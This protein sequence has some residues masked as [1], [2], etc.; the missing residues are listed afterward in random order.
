M[1]ST[2]SPPSIA[3][4]LTNLKSIVELSIQFRGDSLTSTYGAIERL[5][6]TILAIL[7]H[8]IKQNGAD[9][10]EQL[11]QIIVRLNGKSQRYINLLQ[12]IYYRENIRLSVEQWI[13][14]SL[15]K[16]CLSNQL[17]EIE[18][19]HDLLENYYHQSAFLRLTAYY[20]AF[21]L[22]LRTIEFNDP[23]LL[24]QIDPKLSIVTLHDPSSILVNANNLQDDQQEKF[25]FSA[26]QRIVHRRNQSDPIFRLQK[27]SPSPS[28]IVVSDALPT[29]SY[30]QPDTYGSYGSSYDSRADLTETNGLICRNKSST[31]TTVNDQ[32]SNENQRQS[33]SSQMTLTNPDENSLDQTQHRLSPLLMQDDTMFSTNSNS[34][35]EQ[36]VIDTS[37][38][39]PLMRTPRLP[40]S[41]LFW[42]RKGQ[43]LD[44]Y[45]RESDSKTRTDVEKE[46]AHFYLSE[47]ILSAVEQIKFTQQCQRYLG[48][49]CSSSITSLISPCETIHTSSS[50]GSASPLPSSVS[51]QFYTPCN[52]TLS[53]NHRNQSFIG[54]LTTE[55]SI[56]DS[57]PPST[58]DLS[59]R[60][61][62]FSTSQG[63]SSAETIAL[64]LMETWKNYK[65]PSANEL[66]WMIPH[67]EDLPQQLLPLPDGIVIDPNED[68]IV[69]DDG[70]RISCRGN[71]QWAPPREQLIF[72][73]HSPSNRIHQLKEQNYLCA[74]CGRRVEKGFVNLYRYCEYTDKYFCRSCHSNKRSF[75][76]SY[77]LNKWNFSTKHL[78]S[79][80]AFDYL[81]RIRNEAIFNLDDLNRNLFNQ[82]RKLRLADELRWSLFYLHQYVSHCRFAEEKGLINMLKK[83]PTHLYTSPYIY[84]I[85]DLFQTKS[86]EILKVLE[87]IANKLR[88][89][90]L[91]CPL[92][93][94]QGHICQICRNPND[95]IFPFDLENTSVCTV[96]QSC[97]HLICHESQ[98]FA[99]PKCP[100]HKNRTSLLS[101]NRS[102]T[103]T[104]VPPE[105]NVI[106]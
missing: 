85:D 102:S 20:Q 35:Q 55:D 60:S 78:V 27:N 2:T 44:D 105:E 29:V 87:T 90:V 32:Q 94:G 38:P 49:S 81:N 9:L 56:I 66:F 28:N 10:Y 8:E 14:Q 18:H 76:P 96:C 86:G 54:K 21:L 17:T 84:S 23:S 25:H 12:E 1:N 65:V 33:I 62:T 39:T 83:L 58:F 101:N 74:G 93:S 16:Q 15:I 77:I 70:R 51:T 98:N 104:N 48:R 63:E 79:N 13:D 68:F 80:F 11:W 19:D 50:N 47:A 61:S 82:S 57:E 53:K 52:P 34:P 100:R 36:C 5:R 45:I 88:D 71:G 26:H 43:T 24:L 99:C 67:D 40:H 89:H 7:F 41:S 106:D 95:I 92:C 31:R 30:T 4:L 69:T 42:P 73:I 6:S 103:P 72:H 22:C 37:S 91:S 75:L 97:F 59:A 64:T 3:T 46:N